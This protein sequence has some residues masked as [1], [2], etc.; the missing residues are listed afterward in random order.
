MV[1]AQ[2]GRDAMITLVQGNILESKAEALVNP[3]NTVGVM[4]AGLAL[5]FK[6]TFPDNFEAYDHACREGEVRVGKMFVFARYELLG[7]SWIINFPT[8]DHWRHSSKIEYIE[9]GLI[10]LAKVIENKSIK[11]VAIPPLGCGLGGL[12]WADVLPKIMY[13]LE[14]FPRVKIDIF[15]PKSPTRGT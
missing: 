14:W 13:S 4:G 1:P 11:S 2:E 7:P 10:D 9:D 3:V 15:E 12:N 6:R 8:K 5:A